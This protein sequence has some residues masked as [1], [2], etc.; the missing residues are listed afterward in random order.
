VARAQVGYT[1]RVCQFPLKGKVFANSLYDTF[2]K[3][4]IA[5]AS[6]TP[7]PPYQD[8][9][10]MDTFTKA[11]IADANPTVIPPYQDNTSFHAQ[12]LTTGVTIAQVQRQLGGLTRFLRHVQQF[13]T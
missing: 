5:D 12:V 4:H 10:Y 3:A 1:F 13:R 9:R 6:S 8:T 11:H 7:I 2:T